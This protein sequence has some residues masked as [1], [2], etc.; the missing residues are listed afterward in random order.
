MKP[1]PLVLISAGI[2]AAGVGWFAWPRAKSPGNTGPTPRQLLE[3]LLPPLPPLAE[4]ENGWV[5]SQRLHA[6]RREPEL[7]PY[8]ITFPEFPPGDD[9]PGVNRALLQEYQRDNETLLKEARRILQISG[10]QRVTPPDESADL[11]SEESDYRRMTFP[12]RVIVANAIAQALDGH[13]SKSWP[14][15]L[16]TMH[17]GR[18]I[19]ASRCTTMDT[20][21]ACTII[22]QGA[23][24]AAWAGQQAHDS[25][26]ARGLAGDLQGIEDTSSF[27]ASGLDG[28]LA[29]NLRRCW[30]FQTRPAL[31]KRRAATMLVFIAGLRSAMGSETE[32]K[33][34]DEQVDELLMDPD[35]KTKEYFER[36]LATDWTELCRADADAY[37]RLKG[38]APATWAEY[39]KTHYPSHDPGKEFIPADAADFDGDIILIFSRLFAVTAQVRM[40]RVSLLLRAWMYDHEGELPDKLEALIPRYLPELPMDPFDG[41]PL[42]Y[43]KAKIWSVGANLKDDG[44]DG[45]SGKDHALPL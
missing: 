37:R 15:I 7:R 5:L 25:T 22:V 28:I 41:K 43:D 23:N 33:P 35:H 14:D 1:R 26:T 9:E 4:E 29:S 8:L 21:S 10:W 38:P 36:L 42:R 2:V 40:A 24:A 45:V 30:L 6:V 19:A 27:F 20:L 17:L 32:S 11:L 44:G 34:F 18:R 39:L 31:L 3:E 12:V 13:L 16:S